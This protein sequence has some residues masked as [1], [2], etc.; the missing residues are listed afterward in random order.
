M[1][2]MVYKG[3]SR[4]SEG[5]NLSCRRDLSQQQLKNKVE[6]RENILIKPPL[7]PVLP[8]TNISS[9]FC[10]KQRGQQGGGD[11]N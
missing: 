5:L 2:I 4:G 9:T 11:I 10:E 3:Q 1:S 6:S 8:S 7:F